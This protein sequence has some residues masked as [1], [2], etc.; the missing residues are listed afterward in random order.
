MVI[1]SVF[2]THRPVTH[3]SANRVKS[4]I[5]PCFALSKTTNPYST[6][7]ITGAKHRGEKTG[8]KDA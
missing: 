4:R 6:T 1:S 8:R 2:Y 3:E 5:L 7:G